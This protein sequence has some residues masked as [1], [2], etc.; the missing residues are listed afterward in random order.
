MTTDRERVKDL[1]AWGILILF[2]T[3]CTMGL[4]SMFY[5]YSDLLWFLFPVGSMSL[6]MWAIAR[7]YLP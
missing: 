6:V 1:L 2:W 4:I 3:S 7:V 5:W